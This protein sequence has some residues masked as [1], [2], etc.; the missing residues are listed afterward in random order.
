MKTI[1]IEIDDAGGSV[2]SVDGEQ[3]YQC[4]SVDECLEYLGDMLR[5]E[6]PE[7]PGQAADTA[8]LDAASMWNEE[9]ASRPANPNLM[10]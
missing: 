2:V 3:V 1:T 8:E 9:A 7:E 10:R 5:G 4:Q 6:Q